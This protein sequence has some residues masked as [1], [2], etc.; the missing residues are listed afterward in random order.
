MSDEAQVQETQNTDATRDGNEASVQNESVESKEAQSENTTKAS[1]DDS[2]SLEAIM[3]SSKSESEAD[4]KPTQNASGEKAEADGSEKAEVPAWISQLPSEMQKNETFLKFKKIGELAKAYEELANEKREGV[5]LLSKDAKPDEVQAFYEKLGKPKTW[6]GYT[7]KA[8][9][10]HA[11]LFK[12]IAFNANLTQAQAEV[13]AD[14]FSKLGNDML[15]AQ[16]NQMRVQYEE[17]EKAL[18]QEYGNRYQEKLRVL[19]KGIKNFG[20]D[21]VRQKLHNAGLSFDSDIVHMFIKLGELSQEAPN[22][23][24]DAHGSAYKSNAE[25]GMFSFKDL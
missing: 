15:D 1:A 3:T 25:G 21:A 17:T 22:V 14:A 2:A 20:G 18:K 10:E 23:Q 9:D 11:K 5:T 7:L 8:N 16:Q 24:G 12:E 13:V 19:S 4:A 6:D